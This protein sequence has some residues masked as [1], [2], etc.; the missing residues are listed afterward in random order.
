MT[1]ICFQKYI[2]SMTDKAEKGLKW[3]LR[4]S[5]AECHSKNS[6][7][8]GCNCWTHPPA[9]YYRCVMGI[10]LFEK[11]RS[12]NRPGAIISL[13]ELNVI[14]QRRWLCMAAPAF[15]GRSSDYSAALLKR[16]LDWPKG[17]PDKLSQIPWKYLISKGLLQSII[18]A[19]LHVCVCD[20]TNSSICIYEYIQ[21]IISTHTYMFTCKLIL[22]K[23]L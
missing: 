4:W 12:T 1:E 7:C 15:N 16:R 8:Q 6:S 5:F 3:S 22:P 18:T 17:K 9:R 23:Q 20:I 14:F 13:W 10:F 2:F 19:N 11:K 21:T